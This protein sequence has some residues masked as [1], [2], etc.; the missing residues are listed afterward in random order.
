M[1]HSDVSHLKNVGGEVSLKGTGAKK[2]LRN[3]P[4]DDE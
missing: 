2:A 4:A 3:S 1:N